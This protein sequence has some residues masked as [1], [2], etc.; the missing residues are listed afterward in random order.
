[1]PED[2]HDLAISGKCAKFALTPMVTVGTEIT[3][4]GGE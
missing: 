2:K 3:P 4:R 1:V